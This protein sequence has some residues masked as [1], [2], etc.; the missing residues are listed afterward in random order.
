MAHRFLTADSGA[1]TGGQDADSKRVIHAAEEGLEAT[2]RRSWQFYDLSKILGSG[3]VIF[4]LRR[5]I[6]MMQ[7]GV[8]CSIL[9]QSK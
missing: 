4:D 1:K 9:M 5:C 6:R 2:G 8:M 3:F 7:N